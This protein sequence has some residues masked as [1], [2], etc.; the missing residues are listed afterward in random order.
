MEKQAAILFALLLFLF[1]NDVSSKLTQSKCFPLEVPAEKIRIAG[2]FE[3]TVKMNKCIGA[4]HSIDL[5][6]ESR[7]SRSTMCNCCQPA[8][9]EDLIIDIGCAT[10]EGITKV[11]KVTIKNPIRCSCTPCRKSS[12]P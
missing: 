4:C 11:S 3:R 6:P 2:C 5:L 9:F 12:S 10:E 7:S 1:V 8:E